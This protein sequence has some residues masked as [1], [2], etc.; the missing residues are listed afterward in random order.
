MLTVVVW[1]RLPDLPVIVTVTVPVVALPEVEKLNVLVLVAGLMLNEAV[2]P[3]RMPDAD[4]D[5]LPLKP[6][7][8]AMEIVVVPLLRRAT[9]RLAGDADRLKVGAAVTRRE[10]FVEW[11]K[12]LLTPGNVTLKVPRD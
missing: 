11:L 7:N 9:L 12:R 5:T 3:L 2:V 8:C 4:I 6:V 1:V 10:I